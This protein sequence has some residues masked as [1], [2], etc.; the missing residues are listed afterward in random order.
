[1]ARATATSAVPRPPA[2]PRTTTVSP[3]RRPPRRPSAKMPARKFTGSAAPA[4]KSSVSGSGNTRSHGPATTAACPPPSSAA[5]TRSPA[6]T[7]QSPGAERTTPAASSPR[8]AGSSG[9]RLVA[10]ARHQQIRERHAGRAHVDHDRAGGLGSVLDEPQAVGSV[11]RL[12]L[13]RA[14]AAQTAHGAAP[15][16]RAAAAPRRAVHLVRAVVDAARSAPRGTCARAACRRSGRARR[17]PG[18][19][20][21]SR[22]AASA[23]RRT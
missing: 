12:Q 20:G 15:G 19:P 2:A 4:A 16:S 1:M 7:A 6:A 22:R 23:R 11:Q 10:P 9:P 3:A 17:A 18:S 14:H 13:E 8:I 5:Q 21:R